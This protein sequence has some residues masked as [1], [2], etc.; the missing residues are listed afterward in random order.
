M[1]DVPVVFSVVVEY[2]LHKYT[3]LHCKFPLSIKVGQ[4]KNKYA[5]QRKNCCWLSAFIHM[6]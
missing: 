2:G 3:F 4:Y 5:H 1:W 6:K